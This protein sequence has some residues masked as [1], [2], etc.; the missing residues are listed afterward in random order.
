M[1]ALDG[2]HGLVT[3]GDTMGNCVGACMIVVGFVYVK[4]L[5]ATLE[6]NAAFWPA[7]P[8][9]TAVSLCILGCA[10]LHF[11][12]LFESKSKLSGNRLSLF[13][14]RRLIWSNL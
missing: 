2:V 9:G 12:S 13:S 8:S 5:Q 1:E 7:R 4:G 14:L 10:C 3:V 6:S 11:L